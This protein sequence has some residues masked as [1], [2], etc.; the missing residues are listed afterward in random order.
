VAELRSWTPL[1][2]GD[3][4]AEANRTIEAIVQSLASPRTEHWS[5]LGVAGGPAGTAI[6]YAYLSRA[7]P[8]QGYADRAASEIDEAMSTL[9]GT[10]VPPGLYAGFAGVGWAVEHLRHDLPDIDGET[11]EP[12]DEAMLTWLGRQPWDHD[13]DLISGLV[14]LGVYA[15]ERLPHGRGRACLEQVI[16]RLAETAEHQA[17]GL[18]WLTRPE[19]MIPEIREDYPQGYYNLGMAHGVPGVIALL[20]EACAAGVARERARPMLE[21]A[22]RWLLAHRQPDTVGSTFP[23]TRRPGF[24]DAPMP[25]RLAWCYGDL[26]VAAALLGAARHVGEPRW[27]AEALEVA[28]RAAQRSPEQARIRDTGLCHGAVGV[29]HLFNRCFQATGD[30]VLGEAARFWFVRALDMRQPGQGLAGYQAW[31]PKRGWPIDERS[32]SPLSI[33]ERGESPIPTDEAALGWVDDPGLLNGVTG[34]ALA[35]LGAVSA[36]EPSWDRLLLSRIPLTR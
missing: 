22:V 8:G 12:I 31:G 7:L 32:E 16:D 15:L 25:S 21:G 29:A 24:G 27:E 2:E 4:R 11:N 18:A 23:T 3:Q 34:I 17:D 6:L 9:A 30:S 35:L 1:L 33:D 26:G 19:R 5:A 14:G 13:Y 36:I 20:G 28:R 10:V